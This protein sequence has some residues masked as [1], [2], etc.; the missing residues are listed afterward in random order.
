MLTKEN[1]TV[2]DITTKEKGR[3][4]KE[5][6]IS[7]ISGELSKKYKDN[8]SLTS[9][10]IDQNYKYHRRSHMPWYSSCKYIRCM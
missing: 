6:K 8:V 3:K 10:R 2:A 5:T 4:E 1:A 7:P 9:L